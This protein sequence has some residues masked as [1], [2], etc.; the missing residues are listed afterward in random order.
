[1]YLSDLEPKIMELINSK[2]E[3][4]KRMKEQEYEIQKLKA[5]IGYQRSMIECSLSQNRL[6]M[7][8]LNYNHLEDDFLIYKQNLDKVKQIN[9]L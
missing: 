2:Y 3:F 9:E 5:E 8:Y 6:Y 7:S 4:E 1:M